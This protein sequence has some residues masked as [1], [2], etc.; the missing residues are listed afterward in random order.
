MKAP[1]CSGREAAHGSL[2]SP[3]A[4]RGLLVVGLALAALLTPLR[5]L[6]RLPSPSREPLSV[7]PVSAGRVSY[8]EGLKGAFT[9]AS[10][11]LAREA[12]LPGGQL[13]DGGRRKHLLERSEGH[14]SIVSVA[15]KDE[16]RESLGAP[17]C[18]W[19]GLSCCHRLRLQ[20]EYQLIP[21]KER[22]RD[23][24]TGGLFE[25]QKLTRS[26]VRSF[27]PV[28]RRGGVTAWVL[29]DDV[30]DVLVRVRWWFPTDDDIRR[31]A[32]RNDIVGVVV[33]GCGGVTCRS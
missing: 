24:A 20:P 21:R 6:H 18:S 31:F 23:T 28:Q 10:P 15:S 3:F 11:P 17:E 13:H 33:T 25:P 19:L 32:R 5:C 29:P 30:D 2:R 1:T 16:H 7:P 26:G 12:P 22:P 27:V 9:A 4:C 14:A 8:G